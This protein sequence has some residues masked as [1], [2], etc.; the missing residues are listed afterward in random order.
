[1]E[2]LRILSW[3]HDNS[4]LIIAQTTNKPI[5]PHPL[6][7]LDHPNMYIPTYKKHEE[8]ALLSKVDFGSVPNGISSLPRTF[9]RCFSPSSSRGRVQFLPF[10]GIKSNLHATPALSSLTSLLLLDIPKW[11]WFAFDHPFQSFGWQGKGWKAVVKRIVESLKNIFFFIYL[12][13]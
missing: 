3:T 2:N 7:H 6:I 4:Q 13:T 5:Q 8:T 11:R 1:M 10:R 9:G 12:I